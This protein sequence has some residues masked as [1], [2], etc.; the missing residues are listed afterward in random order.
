MSAERIRVTGLL[1]RGSRGFVLSAKD[2]GMWVVD[3]DGSMDQLIGKNVIAEGTIV[4]LDR[5]K[6]DWIGIAS[7]RGRPGEPA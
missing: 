5:L 3:A 4:G 1:S 6:A 2:D 7:T